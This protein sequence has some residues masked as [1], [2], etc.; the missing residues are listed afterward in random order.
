MRYLFV[1]GLGLFL[2]CA[3]GSDSGTQDTDVVTGDSNVTDNGTPATCPTKPEELTIKPGCMAKV[4]IDCNEM[5]Y[6]KSAEKIASSTTPSGTTYQY[7]LYRDEVGDNSNRL[8][9]QKWSTKFL[10]G[11]TKLGCSS[12][13][14]VDGD[15]FI[16]VMFHF[17]E[18]QQ[19][20][21]YVQGAKMTNPDPCTVS[22][23]DAWLDVIVTEHDTAS[24][25]L[26][27]T[28]LGNIIGGKNGNDVLMPIVGVID[29]T[30]DE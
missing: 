14:K 24:R 28:I 15:A 20:R 4:F 30:Y 21:S 23:T 10:P 11:T 29:A 1:T 19:S 27:G 26:K 13:D 18:D 8:S 9:L 7:H 12:I 2:V 22:T 5:D 16:N 25:N 3:C 17:P 6:C